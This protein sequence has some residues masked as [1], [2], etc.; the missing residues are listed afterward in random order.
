M[1]YSSVFYPK[2]SFLFAMAVQIVSIELE[3]KNVP[4]GYRPTTVFPLRTD[5]KKAKQIGPSL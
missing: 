1:Q 3:R 4:L 5:R 2:G